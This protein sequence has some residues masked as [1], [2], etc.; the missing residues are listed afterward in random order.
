M[1]AHAITIG[2]GGTAAVLLHCSLASHQAIVPLAKMLPDLTCTCMDLL[3]H[4]KSAAPAGP[5]DLAAN[6]GAVADIWRGPGWVIGHS[7]GAA[8]ALRFALD[9][10]TRVTRLI[11]IEPVLFAIA[12]KTAGYA[13]FRSDFAPIGQAFASGDMDAAAMHFMALWGDGT[14]WAQVPP[15]LRAYATARMHFIAQSAAD[16]EDDKSGI[17]A[18]GELERL[19]IPVT[20]IRGE[21]SHPV[22][23]AVH[24]ALA[25]RLPNV[26][27]HVISGAG[28]MAP[29]S[30]T[31]DVADIIRA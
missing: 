23:A 5:N 17:C 16:L 15:A 9:Q 1:T 8:V 21:T 28:H 24:D 10:P 7:Y 18:A 31:A 25:R 20:L 29:L 27:Q 13:Q 30:H 19:T 11:L 22:I 14:P 4:G 12:Q 6:A 2:Q 26:S 3:G